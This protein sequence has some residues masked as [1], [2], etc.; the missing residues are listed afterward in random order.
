[1]MGENRTQKYR[2]NA[3][4]LVES[5]INFYNMGGQEVKFHEIKTGDRKFF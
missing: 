3:W 5:K 1:M 2:L 4:K